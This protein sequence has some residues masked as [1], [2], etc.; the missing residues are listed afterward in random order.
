MVQEVSESCLQTAKQ[1][2]GGRVMKG[3]DILNREDPGTG[4]TLNQL[5]DA[6]ISDPKEAKRLKTYIIK[7]AQN[8]EREE[9][10]YE[11]LNQGHG[12]AGDLS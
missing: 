11:H 12:D 5:I 7:E 1:G 2:G 8:G 6:F 4:L 9:V 3:E 10:A